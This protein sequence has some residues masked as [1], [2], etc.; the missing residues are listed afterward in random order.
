M[1]QS[2]RQQPQVPGADRP[3]TGGSAGGAARLALFYGALF[4]VIGV[5]MPFW[6]VWL[7][8][9]GLG[10]EEI[11]AVLAV[12]IAAK[13]IGNPLAAH[14]ADRSGERRRPMVVLA[15][16]AFVA[17]ALFAFARG[18]WSVVAVSVLFFALW[19]AIIPLGESLTMLVAQ[20][21]GHGYGR[22]RLWGSLSFIASAVLA[23]H[24]LAGRPPA[25]VYWLSLAAI[26][27]TVAAAILLPDA[28]VP[29]SATARLPGLDVV[30]RRRFLLFLAATAL[31]QGSHA[32]YYAFG[33]LHWRSVGHSVDRIGGLWAE[34]VI[35]E[36]LLFAVADRLIAR[37]GAERLIVFGG[38]AGV[39]RW[40]VTGLTDALPA[41]LLVQLLHAFSFGATHVAA[42][43]FLFRSVPPE[44]SA[45]AQGIYSAVVMGISFAAMYLIAG[46]LY[47]GFAGAAYLP[48]AGI[49]LAGAAAGGLLLPFAAARNR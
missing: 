18:F 23:G 16:A 32:V 49:A 1:P 15:A 8:A 39:I 40:T 5:Q 25:A 34:G 9:R 13:V 43:H 42:I 35:A 21:G 17:F 38:L 48:M 22:I 30:R 12:S 26:A 46:W 24:V 31:I 29:P 27:A 7:Q 45:T 28:R 47:A 36:I 37:F 4:A 6:P 3:R 19:P 41:L 10:P 33:T 2:S 11:A 20:A 44:L 14:F